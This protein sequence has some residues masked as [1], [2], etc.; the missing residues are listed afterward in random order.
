MDNKEDWEEL[1]KWNKAREQ[2]LKEQYK[3][4]DVVKLQEE[5]KKSEK[6]IKK[7]NKIGG[8]VGKV[9]AVFYIIFIILLIIIGTTLYISKL[10]EIKNKVNVDVVK[11]LGQWRNMEFKVISEKLDSKGNGTLHLETKGKIKIKFDAI[12]KFGDFEHNYDDESLKYFFE[13]LD[14]KSKAIFNV[15]TGTKENGLEQYVIYANIDKL[16]QIDQV[17]EAYTEL[18]ELAGEYFDEYWPIELRNDEYKG[19]F[20]TGFGDIKL[21]KIVDTDKRNY[22]MWHIDNNVEMPGVTESEITRYYKP[23]VLYLYINGEQAIKKVSGLEQPVILMY[24]YKTGDYRNTF[25]I[26]RWNWQSFN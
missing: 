6:L 18:K 3:G 21:E 11:T 19:N 23:N 7:A 8:K 4:V 16:S 17:A 20:I 12:K 13:K 15:E 2:K 14:S 10:E 9:I 25:K 24:Y 5:S 1:E 26:S 22:V